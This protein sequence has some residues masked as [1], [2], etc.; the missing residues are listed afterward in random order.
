MVL[1]LATWPVSAVKLIDV[2]HLAS[3]LP[4]FSLAASASQ[5]WWAVLFSFYYQ[6][7]MKNFISFSTHTLNWVFWK[8]LN[9]N[10]NF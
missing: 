6:I 8:C 4:N 9:L 7:S 2:Y 3:S 1:K 10:L 5:S